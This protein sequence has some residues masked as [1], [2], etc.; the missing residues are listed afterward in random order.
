MLMSLSIERPMPPLSDFRI[1]TVHMAALEYDWNGR[2]DDGK[3][4]RNFLR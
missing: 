2:V 3:T 1:G 4:I